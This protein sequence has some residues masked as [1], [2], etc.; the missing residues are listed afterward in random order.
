MKGG[1]SMGR[2][3]KRRAA[4]RPRP[5]SRVGESMLDLPTRAK[6]RTVKVP[7]RAEPPSQAYTTGIDRSTHPDTPKTTDAAVDVGSPTTT[8]SA[9]TLDVG[10]D[11]GDRERPALE[12]TMV[13]CDEL[14]DADPQSLGLSY[15]F[16]APRTGTAGPV[17]VRF[18]GTH[19]GASAR[20]RA[21][22]F[23]THEIIDPVLPGAGSIT[24]T[25]RVENIAPGA[26]D[27][28]ASVVAGPADLR[29]ASS[30]RA[31]GHTGYGPVVAVKAPG[32]GLGSWPSLVALGAML[33]VALQSALVLRNGLPLLTVVGTSFFACLVGLVGAKV[34]YL[35]E[36]RHR[37]RTG[38]ARWAGMCLQGFVLA[39]MTTMVIGSIVGEVPVLA[40][41]DVTAPGLVLGAGIGRVG[42]WFGGCCA[43]RPTAARWGLWSSDRRLGM[44]RIPVQLIEAAAAIGIGAAAAAVAWSGGPT[45]DGALFVATLAAYVLARQLVFPLRSLPRNTRYGRA[46]TIAISSIAV[47]AASIFLV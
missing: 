35:V 28:T 39:A 11:A 7:T 12:F 19:R 27:V 43:G 32:T 15:T 20:E 16:S 2:K 29:A 5:T 4:R 31:S 38:L 33:A 44:R 45:S 42:C 41:L 47:L 1:S 40:V 46:V 6:S 13:G 25:H 22:S 24:V 23:T 37:P 34:Y 8:R 9:A 10:R 30:I 14:Q 26:W 18:D 36:H 17:T 21:G 3:E